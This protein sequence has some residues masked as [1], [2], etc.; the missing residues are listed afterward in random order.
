VRHIIVGMHKPL[1]HNGKTTH[2]MD[3][4]GEQAIAESDAA[5]ALL[6]K[7]RASLIVASHLHGFLKFEVGGI[8]SYITGGLGAPLDK[9][10]PDYS[11]HHFLQV[12]VGDDG[13]HVTVVRFDGQRSIAEG[14]EK[15]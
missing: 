1:A 6:V 11:F 10:G 7:Y 12:D 2:S 5:L 4:D 9:G 3:A 15:E 14:E 13:L 8:P